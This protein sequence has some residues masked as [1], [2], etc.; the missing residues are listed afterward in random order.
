M[1]QDVILKL[2]FMTK[3]IACREIREMKAYSIRREICKIS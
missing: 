1:A 2:I 3:S